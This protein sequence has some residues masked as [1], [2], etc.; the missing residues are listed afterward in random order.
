MHFSLPSGKDRDLFSA[1]GTAF[2]RCE[3]AKHLLR[4]SRRS[5]VRIAE[6]LGYES[7]SAF[8][9]TFRRHAGTTLVPSDPANEFGNFGGC[10]GLAGG[11]NHRRQL[12]PRPLEPREPPCFST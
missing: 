8:A 1:L 2:R 12:I 3:R 10:A 9:R 6:T 5:I 4:D 7:Q 11:I